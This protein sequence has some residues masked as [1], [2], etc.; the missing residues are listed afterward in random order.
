MPR[1]NRK[2]KSAAIKAGLDLKAVVGLIPHESKKG[3]ITLP[4]LQ[5]WLDAQ[6]VPGPGE[7][8][9]VAHIMGVPVVT[10][11]DVPGDTATLQNTHTGE[12]VTLVNLGEPYPD[13]LTPDARAL[14][15][16]LGLPEYDM[17]AAMEGE[18]VIN[19]GLVKW[20]Q[21]I[22]ANYGIK[23]REPAKEWSISPGAAKALKILR[24]QLGP[25]DVAE[26]K[27][28]AT[29]VILARFATPKAGNA[30]RVVMNEGQCPKKY[31]KAMSAHLLELDL[32]F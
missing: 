23:T 6:A 2:S 22:R 27:P 20:Y 18:T 19:V 11:N 8:E 16:E 9:P 14:M 4:E 26:E 5:S 29:H 21:G 25:N 3:W 31:C 17:M 28:G 15:V 1:F 30:A 7:D 24:R 13:R 32:R 12:S 10:S